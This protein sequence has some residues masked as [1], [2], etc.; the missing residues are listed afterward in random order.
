MYRCMRLLLETGTGTRNREREVDQ[1]LVIL[2]RC[3]LFSSKRDRH[4]AILISILRNP[5]PSF[6]HKY[7]STASCP[8]DPIFHKLPVTPHRERYY[9]SVPFRQPSIP[10]PRLS[11]LSPPK[12]ASH[13]PL[14]LVLGSSPAHLSSIF[15]QCII[16]FTPLPLSL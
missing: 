1:A 7:A 13:F 4:S 10:I 2:R 9:L 16:F 12:G 6:P 15:R 8:P 11:R 14:D 3:L 5:V